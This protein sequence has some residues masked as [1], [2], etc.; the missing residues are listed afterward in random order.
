MNPKLLPSLLILIIAGCHSYETRTYD[1]SVKNNS[2]GPITVWLTKNGEPYEAGWLSPE[3]IA[4]ESPKQTDR[5]IGGV[6]IP[7]GKSADTGPRNGQFGPGT[8]A[9]LRV[10]GG[11]LN[12]DQI[13]ANSS[14][15]KNRV[16]VD[17][18]S[19]K[20]SYIVTGANSAIE[21]QPAQQAP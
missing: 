6:V 2:A 9:V 1:V 20:S 16:D 17:L 3:D 7:Q 18:P 8:R 21:V 12:F 5:A 4:V 11:Q 14:G 13:L 19:G 15:S 10:Y